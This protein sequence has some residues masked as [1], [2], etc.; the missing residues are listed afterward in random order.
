MRAFRR[1]SSSKGEENNAIH[2]MQAKSIFMRLVQTGFVWV[3][4]Y[5]SRA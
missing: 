5:H 4:L 1:E 2:E 3:Q